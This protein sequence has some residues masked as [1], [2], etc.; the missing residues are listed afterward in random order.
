MRGDGSIRLL[1][2]RVFLARFDSFQTWRKHV[3]RAFD[4]AACLAR[5]MRHGGILLVCMLASLEDRSLAMRI[6]PNQTDAANPAMTSLF[7][8][9]HHWRRVADPFR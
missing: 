1:C 8:I 4:V 7:H 6:R 5:V 2:F 3:A 9:V